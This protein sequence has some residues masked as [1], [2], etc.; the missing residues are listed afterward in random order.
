MEQEEQE[1]EETEGM[2]PKAEKPK[3][4]SLCNKE[5]LTTERIKVRQRRF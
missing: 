1:R 5:K 4:V 2:Y 3:V